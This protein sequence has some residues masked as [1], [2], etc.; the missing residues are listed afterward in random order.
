MPAMIVEYFPCRTGYTWGYGDM[1]PIIDKI[2]SRPFLANTETV[3][4]A[5][6][7]L[8]KLWAGGMK[9]SNIL[10]MAPDSGIPGFVSPLLPP[11]FC[12]HWYFGAG[13]SAPCWK[14]LY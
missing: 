4:L 6:R 11:D 3:I 5:I 2:C 13:A 7:F 10:G 14:T 8:Y 12:S 9:K 1:K